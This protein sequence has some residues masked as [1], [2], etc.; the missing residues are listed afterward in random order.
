MTLTSVP[1]NRE[2]QKILSGPDFTLERRIG[3]EGGKPFPF[4]LLKNVFSGAIL[5]SQKVKVND[6]FPHRKS[7]YLHRFW[8]QLS[9][10]FCVVVRD[11]LA[12]SGE[13]VCL[14]TVRQ[15]GQLAR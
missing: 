13:L 14:L 9:E 5:P 15:V 11:L 8:G 4:W 6:F 7:P 10:E 3:R 12:R 2:S 1:I